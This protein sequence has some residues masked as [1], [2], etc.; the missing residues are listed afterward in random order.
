MKCDKCGAPIGPGDL[1]CSYCKEKLV[2]STIVNN[3]SNE[4]QVNEQLKSTQTNTTQN[5]KTGSGFLVFIVIIIV[6]GLGGLLLY[7]A[8]ALK[9]FFNDKGSGNNSNNEEKESSKN[10][11]TSK[12]L[13][14]SYPKTW[15]KESEGENGITL[16][17]DNTIIIGGS[18]SVSVYFSS[19]AAMEEFANEFAKE[20]EVFT[21]LNKE[22][23]EI[24]GITWHK[25]EY[26]VTKDGST[27]YGVLW[28]HSTGYEIY[29]ISYAA[30]KEEFYDNLKSAEE[31]VATA[32]IAVDEEANAKAKKK[33]IGEWDGGNSGYYVFNEDDTLLIY[34][35][36]AKDK[37]NVFYATYVATDK[38]A[39]Y[40]AGYVE[41]V[42]VVTTITK[43]VIDGKEETNSVGNNL[44]YAFQ[45]RD[46]GNL[47]ATNITA[48][49]KY[50]LKR[51]K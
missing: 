43:V 15:K 21:K 41:G 24:K 46:D 16:K 36:S 20:W 10:K 13:S 1:Q 33:L 9:A 35:E 40:A 6:I 45:E 51:V 19:Y 50:I 26:S 25:L 22:E 5:K 27:K 12:K 31:I 28:I 3:Q 23:V 49:T 48:G 47:N 29:N 30:N 8:G 11:A 2:N 32:V 14:L 4:Q 39:T 7:K 42:S 17:K 38:I 34:R 37:N 44:E 18:F